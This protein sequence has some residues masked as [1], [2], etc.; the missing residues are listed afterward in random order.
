MFIVFYIVLVFMMTGAGFNYAI[1]PSL[2]VVVNSSI[3]YL[4]EKKNPDFFQA[5]S[6]SSS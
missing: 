5:A 1:P 2:T 4:N 6:S 3:K